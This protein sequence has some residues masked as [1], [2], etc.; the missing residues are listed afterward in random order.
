MNQLG[1]AEPIGLSIDQTNREHIRKLTS[2][3]HENNESTNMQLI[4]Q[5]NHHLKTLRTENYSLMTQ[6][7]NK[8]KKERKFMV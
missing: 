8:T 6:E 1:L 2:S 5:H 7:N 4:H 3:N